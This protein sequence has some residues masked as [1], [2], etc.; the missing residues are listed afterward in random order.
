MPVS[1]ATRGLGNSD[2]RCMIA[3]IP[4]EAA[5]FTATAESR[6]SMGADGSNG[7]D[8]SVTVVAFLGSSPGQAH[9]AAYP[10][11]VTPG[12]RHAAGAVPE[13]QSGGLAG[14]GGYQAQ[15][16]RSPTWS[17]SAIERQA[18]AARPA[19]VGLGRQHY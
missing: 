16:G 19:G 12:L 17:A 5:G 9:R 4:P 13:G 18:V 3:R 11:R 14:S 1:F 15:V 8:V 7:D 2:S 6:D 10:P